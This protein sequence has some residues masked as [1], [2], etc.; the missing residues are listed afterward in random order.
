MG[1]LNSLISLA[2][3]VGA[4]YVTITYIIPKIEGTSTS[5]GKDD[6][7][8]IVEDIAGVVSGETPAAEDKPKKEKKGKGEWL[9]GDKT[10]KDNRKKKGGGGEESKK[11]K[12]G[13][14][15]EE[16]SSKKS[17]KEILYIIGDE[18]WDY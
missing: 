18:Y 15:E 13:D 1:I 2:V 17:K 7:K 14:E 6:A 16:K 5:G 4:G 10:G 8:K 12:G 11:S 9:S 3:I